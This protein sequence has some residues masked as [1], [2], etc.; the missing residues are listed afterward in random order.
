MAYIVRACV[1]CAATQVDV[2]EESGVVTLSCLACGAT[3]EIEYD[4][5][6]QP[7]IHVR[8]ALIGRRDTRSQPDGDTKH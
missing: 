7:D 2:T 8:I 1:L 5:P 4:P 6:G 3:F